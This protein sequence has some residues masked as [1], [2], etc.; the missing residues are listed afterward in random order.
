MERFE[1]NICNLPSLQRILQSKIEYYLDHANYKLRGRY[2]CIRSMYLK[3]DERMIFAKLNSISWVSN[4]L[5]LHVSADGFSGVQLVT[6]NEDDVL[7]FFEETKD[8]GNFI[9]RFIYWDDKYSLLDGVNIKTLTNCSRLDKLQLYKYFDHPNYM[10]CER[11]VKVRDIMIKIS[12]E[13]FEYNLEDIVFDRLQ[14]LEWQVLIIFDKDGINP[15][16]IHWKD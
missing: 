4:C 2:I 3:E 10:L 14:I 9:P 11:K 12:S 8:K 6:L 5:Q 13:V 16:F 1:I 7:I 15:E